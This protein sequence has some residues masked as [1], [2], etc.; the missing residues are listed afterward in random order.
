VAISRAQTMCIVISSNEVLRPP[1]GLLANEQARKGYA[2][3]REYEQRAW[4]MDVTVNL[5][6]FMS[7]V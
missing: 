4:A 3:L 2:F 5:D 7:P 1:V 6:P